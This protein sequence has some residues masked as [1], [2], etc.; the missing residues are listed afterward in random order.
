MH[1]AGYNGANGYQM[2]IQSITSP[3]NVTPVV[4]GQTVSSA[5]SE[6]TETDVYSYAGTAGQVVTLAFNWGCYSGTGQLDIF[7]PGANSPSNSVTAGCSSSVIKLT[8]PSTGIY[9][10]FVHEAGYNGANSYQINLQSITSPCNVTPVPCSQPVSSATSKVTETD[11]YN[12]NG[13]AGQTVLLIFS[14]GMLQWYS[15]NW[16]FSILAQPPQARISSRTAARLRRTLT[17]PVREITRFSCM[18]RAITAPTA[19]ASNSNAW[20]ARGLS[21]RTVP[22]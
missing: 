19:T 12:F 4:C 21:V 18:K 2:T 8:L 1:E 17:L 6:V 7:Y 14:W 16:I 13:A 11:V 22:A 10:L 3:C 20:A 15:G 5:T 9:Y